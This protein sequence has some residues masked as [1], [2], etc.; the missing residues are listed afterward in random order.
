[1]YIIIP[2]LALEMVFDSTQTA[3]PS[4]VKILALNRQAACVMTQYFKSM[5]NQVK[6]N[7]YS[8]T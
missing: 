5:Q 3:K 8:L 4:A 6:A 7:F 1:M 2:G